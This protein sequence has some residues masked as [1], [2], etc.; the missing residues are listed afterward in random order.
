MR[1]IIIINNNNDR[2][3]YSIIVLY[4]YVLHV[5]I[6][7]CCVT[8]LEASRGCGQG[9]SWVVFSWEAGLAKIL[10]PSSPRLIGEFVVVG[11][12]SRHLPGCWPEAALRS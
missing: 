9:A 12:R 7:Y 1:I 2:I 5:F 6:S 11:L 10:L 8:N 4:L 3:Q